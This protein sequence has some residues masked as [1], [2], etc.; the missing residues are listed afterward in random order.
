MVVTPSQTQASDIPFE[1]MEGKSAPRS[2]TMATPT[3]EMGAM[4]SAPA[5]R[6]SGHVTMAHSMNLTSVNTE[7]LDSTRTTLLTQLSV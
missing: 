6:L 4:H 3:T 1:A 7:H 5:L 2:E